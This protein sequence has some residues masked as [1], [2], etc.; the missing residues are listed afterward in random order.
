MHRNALF[1][2]LGQHYCDFTPIFATYTLH[3]EGK[4]KREKGMIEGK[5]KREKGTISET[6]KLE[7]AET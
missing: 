7:T 5:R 4:R 6:A 1:C 3:F 2:F